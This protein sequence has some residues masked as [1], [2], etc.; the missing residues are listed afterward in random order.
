[1]SVNEDGLVPTSDSFWDIDGYKRTVKRQ[2]EGSRL[3]NELMSLISERAEIEKAYAKQL[4]GWSQKWQHTI[5][6]GNLS[7]PLIHM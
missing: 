1:M 3:C 7:V 6:K 4:K 5:E 2:D